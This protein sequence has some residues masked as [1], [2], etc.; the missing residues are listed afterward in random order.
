MDWDDAFDNSG[1]VADAAEIGDR[2]VKEAAAFRDGFPRGELDIRYGEHPREV[3][4]LFSPEAEPLGTVVF[5]HG[6]YWHM[7]AK[8]DWSHLA[9]GFLAHGW[10]VAIAGYPLAPDLRVS[11]IVGSVG[12]AIA[13]VGK[14]VAGPMRL[15]GHSAGG[16]L[17]SR[18][19]CA[20][21]LS[22]DLSAR[23]ARVVSISGVHDLRPLLGT[24]MNKVLRLDTEEAAAESPGLLDPP[25]Q[26]PVTFWVGADERPE[27]L[28]QNRLIAEAWGL[29]SADVSSVYENKKNHFTVINSLA[30]PQS[31]LVAEILR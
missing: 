23:I 22:D 18:V 15:V 12:S 31:A 21:T 14:Q 25:K 3:L 30:D 7:R 19:V 20:G 6:G 11:Q 26:V 9:N 13:V 16:H 8:S 1:Y 10:A 24:K 4:D 29:A 5:V 17:V 2:W 27:F 28:R